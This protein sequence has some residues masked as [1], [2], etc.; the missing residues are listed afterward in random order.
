VCISTRLY[1]FDGVE[2][3]DFG[4]CIF[5]PGTQKATCLSAWQATGWISN[6]LVLSYVVHL[7]LRQS[8]PLSLKFRCCFR[9]GIVC[10]QWK[11]LYLT[12]IIGM[13]F[14]TASILET[15]PQPLKGNK[16][17]GEISDKGRTIN[18][19]MCVHMNSCLCICVRVPMQ[20]YM[21]V[22]VCVYLCDGGPQI[23]S[24]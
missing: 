6:V 5:I 23:L 10:G 21:Q 24:G 16:P 22:P 12:Q 19:C 4:L 9:A 11:R 15:I 13:S 18:H 3:K 7:V 14:F 1:T 17:L 8:L 2:G 20:A